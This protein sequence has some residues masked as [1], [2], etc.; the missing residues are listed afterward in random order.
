MSHR[1]KWHYNRSKDQPHSSRRHASRRGSR[2]SCGYNNSTKSS[3][4]NSS[5]RKPDNNEYK[6]SSRQTNNRHIPKSPKYDPELDGVPIESDGS[7]DLDDLS[8]SNKP[9]EVNISSTSTP[10]P[11]PSSP[12]IPDH[13]WVGEYLDEGEE[14]DTIPLAYDMAAK[15]MLHKK[16]TQIEVKTQNNDLQYASTSSRLGDDY[17]GK[18]D[19]LRPYHM[20]SSYDN[21][22][23]VKNIKNP[24]LFSEQKSRMNLETQSEN[25]DLRNYNELYNALIRPMEYLAK[26]EKL[27]PKIQPSK[28]SQAQPAEVFDYGHGDSNRLRSP[29]LP[30][31]N[32]SMSSHEEKPYLNDS[33]SKFH[34][35]KPSRQTSRSRSRE[36]VKMTYED[37]KKKY[38]KKLQNPSPT[39]Q[40]F[41]SV[42]DKL[43]FAEKKTRGP[44]SSNYVSQPQTNDSSNDFIPV[45]DNS[46]NRETQEGFP[47]TVL[48]TSYRQ[49][50]SSSRTTED[51]DNSVGSMTAEQPLRIKPDLKKFQKDFNR[52]NVSSDNVLKVCGSSHQPQTT[53][54]RGSFN[55]TR[56]VLFDKTKEK[57]GSKK[58]EQDPISNSRIV[59]RN[60]PRTY[61]PSRYSPPPPPPLPSNR[62]RL[63]KKSTVTGRLPKPTHSYSIDPKPTMEGADASFPFLK[64]HE[65]SDKHSDDSDEGHSI[66][67]FQRRPTKRHSSHD[68]LKTSRSRRHESFVETNEKESKFIPANEHTSHTERFEENVEFGGFK[69]RKLNRPN[70]KN[71]QNLSKR[72][73][74]EVHASKNRDYSVHNR[75][76]LADVLPVP[77]IDTSVM[78]LPME[79]ARIFQSRSV[80]DKPPS[81]TRS[82]S[83][84]MS[85]EK[86]GRNYDRKN[87]VTNLQYRAMSKE[88]YV[89]HDETKQK[90]IQPLM[91]MN[92]ES[93]SRGDSVVPFIE[94]DFDSRNKK[95]DTKFTKY[96]DSS[97]PS[98][99]ESNPPVGG[100]N[101]VQRER[102]VR[103]VDKEHLEDEH[104][105][106]AHRNK[107]SPDFRTDGRSASGERSKD[108][109]QQERRVRHVNNENWK[110]E[111]D[112]EAHRS[113]RSPD[114]RTEGRSASRE[115]SK[116]AVQ[117]ERQ[118]RHVDNENWKDEHDKESHRNKRSPDFRT[119]GRSAS[120][121][122]SKDAVQQE[123]Q[124]RH[125][126]EENWKDEHD[127]EA[128]RN[129]RSPDFRTNEQS[130]SRE[131][132][133]PESKK[134]HQK[135]VRKRGGDSAQTKDLPSTK[136]SVVRE[137]RSQQ[138]IVTSEEESNSNDLTQIKRKP[139]SIQPVIK[140][141]NKGNW[142]EEYEHW[143]LHT[144]QHMLQNDEYATKTG[145]CDPILYLE[146][147]TKGNRRALSYIPRGDPAKQILKFIALNKGD[148]SGPTS[149]LA[150][151]LGKSPDR[152]QSHSDADSCENLNKKCS[153]M[154]APQ[155][156]KEPVIVKEPPLTP[157]IPKSNASDKK[158]N[159]FFF[160][161]KKSSGTGF[162]KKS[163]AEDEDPLPLQKNTS[164]KS[165]ESGFDGSGYKST[166]IKSVKITIT[167]T[168]NSNQPADS[169][170]GKSQKDTFDRK[171]T[172]DKNLST[173]NKSNDKKKA[174]APSVE[175]VFD[176]NCS[177]EVSTNNKNIEKKNVK[178]Q[179][180]SS[181]TIDVNTK[182]E[183][184]RMTRS[185]SGVS[186]QSQKIKQP[187]KPNPPDKKKPTHEPQQID[188]SVK[189]TIAEKSRPTQQKVNQ[190]QSA[191]PTDK[192]VNNDKMETVKRTV[193][194]TDRENDRPRD[195]KNS[196][197]HSGENKT[198]VP[199]QLANKPTASHR[200]SS[201]NPSSSW[202]KS[203]IRSFESTT[204]DNSTITYQKKDY[205]EVPKSR[206]VFTPKQ[207]KLLPVFKQQVEKTVIQKNLNILYNFDKYRKTKILGV[208]RD[209]LQTF[210]KAYKTAC[211][212]SDQ[213][214]YCIWSLF[215]KP[216]K[217]ILD[218]YN[219][220]LRRVNL[221]K[222]CFGV[223]TKT[224]ILFQKTV[225]NLC[226]DYL[227]PKVKY[228]EQF[229]GS[230]RHVRLYAENMFPQFQGES[231][232]LIKLW[233]WCERMYMILETKGLPSSDKHYL[234]SDY[235]PAKNLEEKI[236]LWLKEKDRNP[237][238]EIPDDT[239]IKLV[240]EVH[241]ELLKK[242]DRSTKQ[243]AVMMIVGVWTE[244]LSSKIRPSTQ[245]EENKNVT[246]E[247]DESELD[248]LV[249][250]DEVYSDDSDPNDDEVEI[251]IDVSDDIS[252]I[253]SVQVIDLF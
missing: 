228:R 93:P 92:L 207:E 142:L 26:W 128:H 94:G 87:H 148:T 141:M 248:D 17:I 130:A 54:Y 203:R 119:D 105:K 168:S 13:C 183:Q 155:S 118:V 86:I 189:T 125:V 150:E 201:E 59:V 154:L 204:S 246:E 41:D 1:G 173:S 85:S 250:L 8:D 43:Y 212:N 218:E 77:S 79:D 104:D 166:S 20:G 131:K 235:E 241:C 249:I 227:Q 169:F 33:G 242:D 35:K 121:E 239:S 37:Y 65:A 137:T 11:A 213:A 243:M 98:S 231:H 99:R 126:D 51:L 122:R 214:I 24:E 194:Q 149:V 46:A 156:E 175:K 144:L 10:I 133:F 81:E 135:Y 222:P 114:F 236:S 134:D 186:T 132:S 40:H 108:A 67:V 191:G 36:P 225:F 78:P 195:N 72:L 111:H 245:T 90:S 252:S 31:S 210:D 115:R 71:F 109:V 112:K 42:Q 80:T 161:D 25:V 226:Y 55:D 61:S 188:S 162:Y 62:D 163:V 153:S 116:D 53:Y 89:C 170:R 238:Y 139:D 101:A 5:W 174:S 76:R 223:D 151:S 22:D 196:N 215:D 18:Q 147:V 110:D 123:R 19:N 185:T 113:K 233:T 117:Q 15:E 83:S 199:I 47:I 182:N 140:K 198:T 224:F 244:G 206:P 73:G 120:R 152:M 106:E 63:L 178:P 74:D 167:Q 56:K 208:A 190:Q 237:L 172:D 39:R 181:N 205:I 232:Y 220:R 52:Q 229:A 138:R 91:D 184:K 102:Q 27:N 192:T 48:T 45:R 187:I 38:S 127:K 34:Y 157:S 234:L 179:K 221:E 32:Q 103:H 100:K 107:G 240:L 97:R 160:I 129:K 164:K 165:Q 136:R 84:N 143:F 96:R 209:I 57:I 16:P 21:S 211:F 9:I 171:I 217:D 12:D 247:F 88:R 29:S 60:S 68:I 251:D 159:E 58:K 2:R 197:H 230:I 180:N 14:K 75:E 158:A 4:Y 49:R 3:S 177:K 64:S 6:F 7:M 124:V 82:T 30:L 253:S 70:F 216:S 44:N 145:L 66:P 200:S 69:K 23:I 50:R 176:K 28:H 202:N 193:K 146:C 95:Y 219:R